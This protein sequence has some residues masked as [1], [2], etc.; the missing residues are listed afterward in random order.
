MAREQWML[1][2]ARWLVQN[3]DAVTN[4]P[5]GELD[6]A[7]WSAAVYGKG[8]LGFDAIRRE[9][10][11][12]AFIAALSTYAEEHQFRIATPWELKDA[13][14]AASGQNLDALWSHW[15]DETGLT[16]EEVES[17]AAD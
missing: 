3:G 14:A 15:F 7:V 6:P 5:A 10:G 9:I 16:V 13:F 1:K 17:F 8:S 2:P 11:D 12:E 4:L